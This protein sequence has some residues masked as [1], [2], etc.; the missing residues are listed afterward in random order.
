MKLS[1]AG[2]RPSRGRL[3]R[4]LVASG[5]LIA[6]TSMAAS[7]HVDEYAL[8]PGSASLIGPRMT[9]TPPQPRPRG[10][11]SM[12]DV[13]ISQMTVLSRF[14]A[15]LSG[16]PRHFPGSAFGFQGTAGLEKYFLQSYLTMDQAKHDAVI[17]A[18]HQ[19]EQPIAA[20]DH[21][22][23]VYDATSKSTLHLGDFVQAIN[24]QPVATTCQLATALQGNGP[25]EA[26]VRRG[27][28][29]ARTGALHFGSPKEIALQSTPQHRM[30]IYE[31][32]VC[33]VA[34]TTSVGLLSANPA[35]LETTTPKVTF[36]TKQIG[37]P[38][39]GFAMA[40]TLV[41][42]LEHG[43]VLR[44]RS[45]ASTGTINAQGDIGD[46][47]GVP[48]KAVAVGTAGIR[49]F[50]VPESEIAAARATA[51]ASVEVIGVRSLADAIAALKSL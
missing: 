1:I 25:F 24:G 43:Q 35:Q 7:I 36:A 42:Q 28:L 27:H 17:A 46:V 31:G 19:A 13:N 40:L 37:G 8:T 30:T 49:W 51:P 38:S 18:F 2:Q 39:A 48:E 14:I 9:L 44:G 26:T 45:V 41:D 21:G 33:A 6:A 22:L 11:V 20:I 15:D 32:P 23:L 3:V 16:S 34:P 50:F 10:E 12:V 5:V 29:N 4:L 47:G